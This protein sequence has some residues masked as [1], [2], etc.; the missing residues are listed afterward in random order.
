MIIGLFS[1]Y[2]CKDRRCRILFSRIIPA[3]FICAIISKVVLGVCRQREYFDMVDDILILSGLATIFL[4]L[5]WF[6]L[7]V[8]ICRPMLGLSFFIFAFYTIPISFATRLAR[9]FHPVSLDTY[10]AMV[11]L[12]LS[13]S[14]LVG[15]VLRRFA[16]KTGGRK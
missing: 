16:P 8:R 9:R 2:N 6:D 1:R 15:I 13:I 3:I 7:V 11:S 12:A 4:N 14:I 5:H 10:L